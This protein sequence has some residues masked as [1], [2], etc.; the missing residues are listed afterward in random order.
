MKP[1][2]T[3]RSSASTNRRAG[4]STRP[5]ATTRPSRTATSARRRG[6]PVPSTT[7]PPAI[8]RSSM[9]SGLHRAHRAPAT[10]LGL[11]A[12]ALQVEAHAP[13]ETVGP[14]PELDDLLCVS[15]LTVVLVVLDELRERHVLIGDVHDPLDHQAVVV[16]E[17]GDDPLQ[18]RDVLPTVG[19]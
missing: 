10:D 15:R 17:R 11:A 5:T 2:A 14:Q 12:R 13:H 1:G 18:E 8:R 6:A 19:D 7:S 3:T 9:R 4:S 16:A